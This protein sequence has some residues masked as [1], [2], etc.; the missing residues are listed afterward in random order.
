LPAAR[1][2]QALGRGEKA[3]FGSSEGCVG[4]SAALGCTARK[5]RPRP[6]L[7]GRLSAVP[8]Q[9]G[10]GLCGSRLFEVVRVPRHHPGGAR[11]PR[12]SHTRAGRLDRLDE[13]PHLRWFV[14]VVRGGSPEGLGGSP[15]GARWYAE[16]VRRWFEVVRGGS[17]AT[18]SSRRGA[19]APRRRGPR[20]AAR[21]PRRTRWS[22]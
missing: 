16:V 21:R 2:R 5:T 6:R 15:E 17:R 22:C 20:L 14:E 18:S 10:R 19:P 7:A 4:A 1:R 8:S 3:A 9:L 11:P 12:P 13:P